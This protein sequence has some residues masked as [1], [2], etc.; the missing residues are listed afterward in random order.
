MQPY[1]P[2]GVWRTK[3]LVH[4]E[5]LFRLTKWDLQEKLNRIFNMNIIIS[6]SFDIALPA[7]TLYWISDPTS[8]HQAEASDW[9]E[10][11]DNVMQRVEEATEKNTEKLYDQVK[12]WEENE[13]RCYHCLAPGH[14]V[15]NCPNP[16]WVQTALV[17]VL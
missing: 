7:H 5:L 4:S 1:I 10:P 17:V 11:C 6:T 14:I 8:P 13:R 15:R 12:R 9:I 3:H 2:K 16:S